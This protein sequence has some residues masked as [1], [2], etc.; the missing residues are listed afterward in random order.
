MQRRAPQMIQFDSGDA[1]WRTL[2]INLPT[3][4][5]FGS[6]GFPCPADY[7]THV[8]ML[9]SSP[10]HPSPERIYA[11]AQRD[12]HVRGQTGCMFAR[13]A[14]GQANTLTWDYVVV[15][16]R[17]HDVATFSAVRDLV[18]R[19]VEDPRC[20]ILS[21]LFPDVLSP[22]GLVA[23][24]LGLVTAGPFWLERDEVDASSRR[25]H[26]RY[27][28]GNTGV[29]AWVM[30]FAP[31]DFLPPT[32]RGPFSELV[33]RVKLKP[34]ELFHRLNQDR[35]VAHLADLPLAMTPPRWEHRWQSTLRRTRMVL[36]A[37]PDDISAARATL[38][39]PVGLLSG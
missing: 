31:L 4:Q 7:H 35:A 24:I 22:D 36:D 10:A 38:S 30:A 20:Q 39:V 23:A 15:P 6:R 17:N 27:P 3:A 12:W 37:E 34:A 1:G 21:V 8:D 32:R 29:Q 18:A 28:L 2:W 14:A 16:G 13:L 25:L 26:L 5:T 19:A 33:I 11:L 9:V